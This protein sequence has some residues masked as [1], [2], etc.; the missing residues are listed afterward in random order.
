MYCE[1]CPAGLNRPARWTA[2]A[3]VG[4]TT[5]VCDEHARQAAESGCDLVVYP[6]PERKGPEKLGAI[7]TRVLERAR[8]AAPN[9]RRR[10]RRWGALD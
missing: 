2:R 10:Y 5:R 8:D 7:L 6:E 9:H 3:P 1:L 4:W